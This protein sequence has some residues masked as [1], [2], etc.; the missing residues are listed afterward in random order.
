MPYKDSY[1]EGVGYEADCIRVVIQMTTTS[2]LVPA[3]WFGI[4]DHF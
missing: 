4:A 2:K 1:D 3:S